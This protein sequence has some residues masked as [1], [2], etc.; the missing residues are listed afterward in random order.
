MVCTLLQ[1]EL[2][3]QEQLDKAW[4]RLAKRD[5]KAVQADPAH[6]A[7]AKQ[8]EAV[9]LPDMLEEFLQASLLLSCS[10]TIPSLLYGLG[11]NWNEAYLIPTWLMREQRLA[12]VKINQLSI[13]PRCSA[14]TVADTVL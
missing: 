12:Q 6:V 7:A 11:M 3:A 13:V 2:H 1:L 8:P 5:A 4:R 10:H 14:L 9:F